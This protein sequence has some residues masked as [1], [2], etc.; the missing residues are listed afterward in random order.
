MEASGENHVLQ[1]EI[2]ENSCTW[3][4]GGGGLALDWVRCVAIVV[5]VRLLTVFG[6]VNNIGVADLAVDGRN[7][8]CC[9]KGWR[10]DRMFC[11]FGKRSLLRC[12][13]LMVY[14]LLMAYSV[15]VLLFSEG[16][17]LCR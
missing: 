4:R 8:H 15:V 1:T 13:K 2:F 9:F 17:F 5:E 16:Q 12:S 10:M 7:V 6:I 3:G 14:S 11:W